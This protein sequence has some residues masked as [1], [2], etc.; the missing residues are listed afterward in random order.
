MVMHAS[1]TEKYHEGEN[2]LQAPPPRGTHLLLWPS[3]SL[4]FFYNCG[5]TFQRPSKL[6]ALLKRA[7]TLHT[8]SLQTSFSVAVQHFR[9]W[10]LLA[11]F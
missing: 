10:L 11:A 5:T 2:L 9:A 4:H 6:P 3:F 7:Q 8:L 1:S